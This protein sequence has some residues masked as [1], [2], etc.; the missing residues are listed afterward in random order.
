MIDAVPRERHRRLRLH[1]ESAKR[2]TEPEEEI[3]HVLL[4]VIAKI[5][6]RRLNLLL[7][8]AAAHLVM[9][10]IVHNDQI[11][12]A[13]LLQGAYRILQKDIV[14]P[15][16]HPEEEMEIRLRAHLRPV[17]HSICQAHAHN[18]AFQLLRT[19]VREHTDAQDIRINCNLHC[20]SPFVFS[21]HSIQTARTKS[22]AIACIYSSAITT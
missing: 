9:L 6:P 4:A 1:G 3:P 16:P 14:Q 17:I 22:K 7:G 8:E 15:R 5:R 10:C 12:R 13:A 20:A 19:A 2:G 21:P 18:G 11:W